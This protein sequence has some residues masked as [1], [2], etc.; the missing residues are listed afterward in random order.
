MP[1][2]DAY[3]FVTRDGRVWSKPR[4]DAKGNRRKGKWLKPEVIKGYHRVVFCRDGV[5]D[6]K[7]V[8][9]LVLEA[10]VGPCPEGMECRHLDGNSLNNNLGNLAW[11]THLE[12]SQDMERH[13]HI[14][15][16]ERNPLSKAKEHQVRVMRY[17]REVAKFPA[18]ELA[19][20]FGMTRENVYAICNGHSWRHLLGHGG[21]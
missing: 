21:V 7:L 9:R 3:Y 5:P 18:K 19:W 1:K 11:G 16:G 8:H 17:L 4:L 20:H 2:Y 13:G 6:K 12:N 10:Y 14:Y 15:R